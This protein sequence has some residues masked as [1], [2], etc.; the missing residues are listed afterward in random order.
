MKYDF[1]KMTEDLIKNLC[2]IQV[3]DLYWND[4]LLENYLKVENVIILLNKSFVNKIY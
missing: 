1:K 2:I 4:F 3:I